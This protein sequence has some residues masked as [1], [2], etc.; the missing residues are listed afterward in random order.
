MYSP[1]ELVKYQ[2]YRTLRY[3]F[4]NHWRIRIIVKNGFFFLLIYIEAGE[5]P[6][7]LHFDDE[8]I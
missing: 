6:R 2:N 4:I 7:D 1:Y 3:G 8:F 5:R